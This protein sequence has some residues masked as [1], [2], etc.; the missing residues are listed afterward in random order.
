M[1]SSGV[2]Y[3]EWLARRATKR[4]HA[5]LREA[6]VS[7]SVLTTIYKGTVATLFLDAGESILRQKVERLEW[8][9]LAHGPVSRTLVSMLER[10]RGDAR[11]HIEFL[12]DNLGPIRGLRYCLERAS[13]DYIIPVDADDLL[14]PD[15]LS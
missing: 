4:Q 12:P 2:V 15:A 14:T 1:P 7:F 5:V 13:G 9:I 3:P 10:L 6:P 8:I 11:C